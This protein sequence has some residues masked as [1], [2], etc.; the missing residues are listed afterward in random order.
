MIP[1]ICL[2]QIGDNGPCP[3]HYLSLAGNILNIEK[4]REALKVG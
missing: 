1:C 4:V 2:K 3:K